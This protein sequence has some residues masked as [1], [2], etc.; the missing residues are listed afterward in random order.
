MGERPDGRT[1]DRI[2]NDGDYRKENCRWA[3]PQE[4]Q[5]HRRRRE[6]AR[7]LTVNGVTRT[8][9]EWARLT[10]IGQETLAYRLKN[11]WPSEYALDT[12]KYHKNRP[13]PW[14]N[15]TMC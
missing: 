4:Q 1:L 15:H 14:K 3:T 6:D 8:L 11:G 9:A 5:E 7:T 10:G 2:D 12:T 13:P